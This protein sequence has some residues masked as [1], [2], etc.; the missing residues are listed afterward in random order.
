MKNLF[1]RIL[2]AVLMT[3]FL[4]LNFPASILASTRTIETRFALSADL[5]SEFSTRFPILSAGR[6]G[7]EITWAT[8]G[9]GSVSL[10][11]ILIRPD[12]SE[13]ARKSGASPLRLEYRTT[14]SEIDGFIS[15]DRAEWTVKII[16]NADANRREVLGKLR[17]T[18]PVSSRNLMDTQFTLLGS[19]NAQEIPFVVPAPGRIVI[20]A[21]WSEDLLSPDDRQRALITLSLI[22]PGQART[23]ARRQG[24]S[25]LRIEHQVTERELDR[26][27]RWIAR[28][29]NDN[30]TKIKG[31]VRVTYTPSL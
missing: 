2:I 8:G 31:R 30:Q 6:I 17:A 24:I 12:R 27:G 21:D 11:V 7:L 3:V 16:N 19:G 22:H 10:T 25:P 13:A 23:H 28:V 1:E 29:Q 4:A 9:A 20:E 5:R 18:V 15:R 14:E 26:G